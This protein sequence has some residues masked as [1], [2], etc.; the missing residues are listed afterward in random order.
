[1]RE[2]DEAFWDLVHADQLTADGLQAKSSFN[3]G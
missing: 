2:E 3:R 1:M